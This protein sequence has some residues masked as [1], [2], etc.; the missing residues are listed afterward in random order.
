M[1]GLVKSLY[2]VLGCQALHHGMIG[3]SNEQEKKTIPFP[4]A[5]HGPCRT[6]RQSLGEETSPSQI[7][8]YRLNK[9]VI[10]TNLFLA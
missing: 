5:C 2:K 1:N 3:N 4:P 7:L 6:P 10:F 8:G 9:E